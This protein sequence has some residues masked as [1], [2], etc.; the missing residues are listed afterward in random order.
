MDVFLFWF[1]ESG[2]HGIRTAFARPPEIISAC[3]AEPACG[4]IFMLYHGCKKPDFPLGAAEGNRVELQWIDSHWYLCCPT[5][6]LWR[7]VNCKSGSWMLH[8]LWCGL[9]WR[10]A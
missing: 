8:A 2:L 4:T 7:G 9:P 3:F 10:F 5:G 1:C 6:V